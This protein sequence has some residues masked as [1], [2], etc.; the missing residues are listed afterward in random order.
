M[1]IHRTGSQDQDDHTSEAIDLAREL[2]AL[3]RNGH[4]ARSLL[5]RAFAC[6]PLP[7]SHAIAALTYRVRK[8]SRLDPLQ[9]RRESAGH[10][11]PSAL[12]L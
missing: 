4:D 2:D 1:I 6:G 9:S 12:G 7:K 10:A 11:G 5:D 3:H 8:L